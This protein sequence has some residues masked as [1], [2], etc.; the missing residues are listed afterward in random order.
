MIM[1]RRINNMSNA[2]IN[3]IIKAMAY[4]LTDEQVA[5]ECEISIEEAAAFRKDHADEITR[6]AGETHA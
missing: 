6:K 3:E 2:E 1:T 4:G 5:E